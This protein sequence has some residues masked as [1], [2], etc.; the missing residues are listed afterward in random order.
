VTL[1]EV[2]VGVLL[3]LVPLNRLIVELVNDFH[4]NLAVP[5]IFIKVV[6]VDIFELKRVDPEPE[7]AL[8]T[9]AF[10]IVVNKTGFVEI[11]LFSLIELLKTVA[12]VE[13]LSDPDGVG[14]GITLDPVA[15]LDE[16]S[17]VDVLSVLDQMVGSLDLIS[18]LEVVQGA[19]LLVQLVEHVVHA[20]GILNVPAEVAHLAG[21]TSLAHV[22]VDP[23]DQDFLWGQLHQIFDVLAVFEQAVDLGA[24]LDLDLLGLNRASKL[25]GDTQ[26]HVRG[27][28]EE[29]RHVDAD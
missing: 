9:R 13:D 10:N 8:L 20:F 19:L 29:G 16:L 21:L 17:N 12:R 6:D 24:V 4:K 23:S 28:L 3:D 1:L 15:A 25:P 11:I 18:V 2:V 7:L 27:L 26:Q 22:V 14:T 5:N